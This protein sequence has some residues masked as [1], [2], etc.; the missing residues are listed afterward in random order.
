MN[1]ITSSFTGITGYTIFGND[2]VVSAIA[3]P[4]VLDW[5]Q[6][7][8]LEAINNKSP[9]YQSINI[10]DQ[11]RY[12]TIQYNFD[13]TQ[14]EI[15]GY[16]DWGVELLQC[17]YNGVGLPF[18]SEPNCVALC[19]DDRSVKALITNN[20]A[21]PANSGRLV[22][23]I[24][25]DQAPIPVTFASTTAPN[26]FT[27]SL[28]LGNS[29]IVKA[30]AGKII[31][32]TGYSTA[33]GFVQIHNSVSVP[34]NGTIPFSSFAVQAN[35]NFFRDFIEGGVNLSTGIVFTFSSTQPLL[36]IGTSSVWFEAIYQ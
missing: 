26:L 28:V 25:A 8:L 12:I 27:A 20:P 13:N 32:I 21:I 2:P 33:S 19:N 10:C 23:G 3:N 6:G 17:L 18:I 14:I 31:Q 7:R 24:P 5:L 30:S 29:L 15:T 34:P 35:D 36:T 4:D 11:N 1:N 9:D 16:P 22:V